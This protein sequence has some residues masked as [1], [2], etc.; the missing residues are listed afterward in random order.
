MERRPD[1]QN[2][3]QFPGKDENE[4]RRQGGQPNRQGGE[5]EPRKQPLPGDAGN[6]G[7]PKPGQGGR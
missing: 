4:Q 7:R 2:P 1:E 5:Q 3:Q 6:P